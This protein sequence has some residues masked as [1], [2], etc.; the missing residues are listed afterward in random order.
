MSE[1]L[2]LRRGTATNIASFTGAQGECVVD[3]TNNRIAVHDGATL[4]GWSAA[5]LSE[6]GAGSLL[7]TAAIAPHGGNVQIGVIEQLVSGLSG[8]SV[9]APVQIPANCIVFAV[10]ARVTTA[11]SGAA[12]WELGVSGA[13]N[14][15]GSS[16][17]LSAGST[18]DG[19]IGPTA[20]YSA[21]TLVLTAA[22][23][24]F[25]AGAVRL[26][27]CYMLANPSTS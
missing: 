10:S 4:G 27:I 1:Q 13:L 26:S 7:A 18:N 16:L 14:Q 11:I 12:S 23:S 3:T 2:Q 17:S 6:V 20:F 15:F 19:L 24:N 9:N 25:T 22:G 21:T 8:A 5:K